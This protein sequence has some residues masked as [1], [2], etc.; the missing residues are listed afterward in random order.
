MNA[1]HSTIAEHLETACTKSVV[2]SRWE[3]SRKAVGKVFP[4]ELINKWQ[5]S[6]DTKKKISYKNV[7]FIEKPD[8]LRGTTGGNYIPL[9]Q[10]A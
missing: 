4:S 8:L 2:F 7:T 6:P 9:L 10:V 5:I 3:I 1:S